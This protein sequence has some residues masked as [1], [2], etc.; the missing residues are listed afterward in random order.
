LLV[1]YTGDSEHEEARFIMQQV[2]DL[3]A[4]E[5]RRYRDFAVLYR[6]NVQ[7]RVLEEQLLYAGIPYRV[8]GGLKFY[9]RQE[10]K[11]TLAYLRFI[12][13]PADLISLRR[14]IN[15]P[16]RGIGAA[17]VKKLLAFSAEQGLPVH[18]VLERA[19]EVP[20]L[21]RIA[22]AVTGF[23]ELMAKLRE[24]ALTLP[25]PQLVEFVLEE[26]GYRQMLAAERT[27]EATERLDNLKEFVAVAG[28]FDRQ[29]VE[30][31]LGAFLAGVSLVADIDDYHEDDDAVVLMTMHAAKGLE[32]PVVFLAGM[33][34]G[35][36]PHSRAQ[37]EERQLEEERRLCYVGITRA[38]ERL[39]LTRACRRMVFG[40]T[41]SS[42]PSRF[43]AEL[44]GD[45]LVVAGDG[46]AKKRVSAPVTHYRYRPG[47][48]ADELIA[49]DQVEHGVFG[50]GVVVMASGKGA[51]QEVTIAFPEKGIKR[52]LLKYAP[53]KKV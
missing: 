24:A 17:T 21:G 20:N 18:T 39:F 36:F 38:R 12:V 26:T 48:P 49:G 47:D 23:S 28:E 16:K 31:D 4:A 34:E 10:I 8:F 33:E 45:L 37:F 41:V 42:L 9:E 22:N 11:D 2:K 1:T 27:D 53:L 50:S 51:E 29:A 6:M 35:L 46:A 40:N 32:F 15:A 5:G 52:F 19:A 30:K 13:N 44:P 3:A 7:S 25:V 43:L 14:V